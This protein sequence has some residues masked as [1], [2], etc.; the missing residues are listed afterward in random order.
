MIF[1]FAFHCESRRRKITCGSHFQS[2]FFALLFLKQLLGAEVF[3]N[4]H[5][6]VFAGIRDCFISSLCP[7][8]LAHRRLFKDG[9]SIDKYRVE[10]SFVG[11]VV[12]RYYC[13]ELYYSSISLWPVYLCSPTSIEVRVRPPIMPSFCQ[14]SLI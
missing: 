7:L 11:T 5:D 10:V 4:K 12:L 9:C 6:A 2:Y 14:T 8:C 1:D 13:V 3:K